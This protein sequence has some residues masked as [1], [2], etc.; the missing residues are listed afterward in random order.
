MIIAQPFNRPVPYR[1]ISSD[2]SRPS[3][4]SD[5]MQV[6]DAADDRDVRRSSGGAGNHVHACRRGAVGT[7]VD[8]R[9]DRQPGRNTQVQTQGTTCTFDPPPS[10]CPVPSISN[11][12]AATRAHASSELK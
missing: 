8:W 3:T 6:F 2:R 5:V 1:C 12:N 9:E 11:V 4:A 7:Q 10:V